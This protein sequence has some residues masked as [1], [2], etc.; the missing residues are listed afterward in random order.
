LARIISA[1]SQVVRRQFFF[2]G[3]KLLDGGQVVLAL[4]SL[5]CGN[6]GRR[7]W[8]F[9]TLLLI[10]FLRG[11]NFG[12]QVQDALILCAGVIRRANVSAIKPFD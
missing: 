8:S 6:E 5:D 9:W 10:Q 2:Y 7:A 1:F 11:F 3:P 4:H 12:K